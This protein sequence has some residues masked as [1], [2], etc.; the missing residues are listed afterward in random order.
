MKKSKNI[1]QELQN[2]LGRLFEDELRDIYW[3]EKALAKALPKLASNA[4]SGNLSEAIQK[5]LEETEEH[6]VRCEQIFK[7]IGKEPRGKK[8]E[9]ME[10]LI[11]EAESIIEDTEEGVMRDAGIISAAQKVEHYEIA[12]YG[13][14]RTFAETIGLE[15]AASILETTLNEEKK[16][17]ALLTD[18]AVSMINEEAAQEPA[19]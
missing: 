3:A 13:T 2:K 7:V 4:S 10:G 12:S 19:E 11:K 9:A 17:D 6:I 5:H 1:P 14:L 15:E 8:C 16:T 18:L